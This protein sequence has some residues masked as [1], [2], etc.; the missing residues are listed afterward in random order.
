MKN[1]FSRP[2]VLSNIVS[3]HKILLFQDFLV[4]EFKMKLLHSY[5]NFE[6]GQWVVNKIIYDYAMFFLYLRAMGS[7]SNINTKTCISDHAT[8]I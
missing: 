3:L 2:L 1:L 5:T 8:L 4:A 6:H 7:S